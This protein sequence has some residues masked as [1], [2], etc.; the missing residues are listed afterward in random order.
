M[1]LRFTTTTRPYR[2]GTYI[3]M[4]DSDVARVLFDG[5]EKPSLMWVKQMSFERSAL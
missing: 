4:V 3:E 5:D 2:T 1:F